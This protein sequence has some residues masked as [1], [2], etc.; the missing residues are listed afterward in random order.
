MGGWNSIVCKQSSRSSCPFSLL[1]LHYMRFTDRVYPSVRLSVVY[2]VGPLT[3]CSFKVISPL[4]QHQPCSL[5][6]ISPTSTRLI[7]TL[8]AYASA[9]YYLPLIFILPFYLLSFCILYLVGLHYVSQVYRIWCNC[10]I[11]MW[12]SAAMVEDCNADYSADKA[13]CIKNPI[14]PFVGVWADGTY[15]R[16]KRRVNWF[17]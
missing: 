17:I 3:T 13:M 5:H 11:L 2:V 8:P 9:F 12:M 7:K 10:D 16:I 15:R 1:S 6:V 4:Q 14:L